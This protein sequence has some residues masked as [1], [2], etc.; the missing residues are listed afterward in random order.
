MGVIQRE[1]NTPRQPFRQLRCLVSGK[2][3]G[4]SWEPSLVWETRSRVGVGACREVVSWNTVAQLNLFLIGGI[5]CDWAVPAAY[6]SLNV[7]CVAPGCMFFSLRAIVG[8]MIGPWIIMDLLL[9]QKREAS[10]S[11]G[12]QVL[13]TSGK[14]WA[15][16][17][18]W[19]VGWEWWR[20]E[21][22][23][24]IGWTPWSRARFLKLE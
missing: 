20:V 24:W 11:V 12:R 19:V 2:K 16:G 13:L 6:Q 5:H 22:V 15:T 18:P 8:L 3:T 9:G 7:L 14:L 1:T 21:V 10:C 4:G 17:K 23:Q